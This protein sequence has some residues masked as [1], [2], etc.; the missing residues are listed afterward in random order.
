ME[1]RDEHVSLSPVHRAMQF[2]TGAYVLL[3][4]QRLVL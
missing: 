1:C 2:N 4:S 3:A